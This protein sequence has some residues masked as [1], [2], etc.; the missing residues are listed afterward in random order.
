MKLYSISTAQLVPF[1]N[2]ICITKKVTEPI[3]EK[4]L[5]SFLQTT[6]IQANL[7]ITK[8]SKVFYRFIEKLNHY[9]IYLFQTKSKKAILE[10]QL[11]ENYQ[12]NFKLKYQL[13]ITDSFCTIYFDGKFISAFEN[14]S[15]EISDIVKF[16][17]FNHKI[18]INEIISI[19]ANELT[20]L[21]LNIKNLK[22]LHYL[23]LSTS[24]EGYYFLVYLFL[25]SL[26]SFYFYTINYNTK[27]TN[28]S[29]Y[30]AKEQPYKNERVAI[31]ITQFIEKLNSNN[32]KLEVLAY[33]QK[34]IAKIQSNHQNIYN[35][36]ALYKKDMKIIKLE[37]IDDH[38]IVAEVEIEL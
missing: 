18:I 31:K 36:L 4:Y 28:F 5:Q 6:L 1:S 9:E 33:D 26:S 11:F 30:I 22:P 16:V 19:N 38:L 8:D 24:Y 25:I 3:F 7:T 2:I 14:K 32:I 29:S 34:L 20:Q 27:E 23:H 12:E 17:Q 37:K 21:K 10:F 15:Y 35:F 13:F